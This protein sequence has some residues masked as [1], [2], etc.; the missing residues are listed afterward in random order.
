MVSFA[1]RP[2]LP[3]DLDD[4]WKIEEESFDPDI[5]EERRIFRERMETFPPGF[6]ILEGESS[7]AGYLCSELWSL[8][9]DPSARDFTLGHSA[10]ERHDPCGKTLYISSFGIRAGLRGRGLGAAFFRGFLDYA[11]AGIPHK[12]ILLLVSD[13]WTGARAVYAAEGFLQILRLPGFFRFSDGSRADGLVLKRA[14]DVP[15]DGPG[16]PAAPEEGSAGQRDL[17]R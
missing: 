7:P 12:E 8:E 10:R 1:L 6:V 15:G 4:I 17:F 5:R 13:T 11:R 2:A 3:A 14:R 16:R 9:G